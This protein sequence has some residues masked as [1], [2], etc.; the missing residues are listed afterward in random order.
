L[1][2][3]GPNHYLRFKLHLKLHRL[4]LD[5]KLIVTE[6]IENL[7][8]EE[9]QTACHERGMISFNVSIEHLQLQLRQW[10]DLQIDKHIPVI[11][12]LLSHGFYSPENIHTTTV[13]TFSKA[14]VC[15]KNTE[16][17]K[18]ALNEKRNKF[19]IIEQLINQKAFKGIQEL[20]VSFIF[21]IKLPFSFQLYRLI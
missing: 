3:I 1:S 4:K 12:L 17:I 16:N 8:I 11:I 7:N 9:L 20:E 2:P 18:R 13:S 10:L 14:E 5:D 6:G 15:D 21:H 19:D